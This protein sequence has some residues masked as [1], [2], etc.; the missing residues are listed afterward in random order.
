M[1]E[2]VMVAAVLAGT[3]ILTGGAGWVARIIKGKD[4]N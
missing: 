2:W 3:V 4:R 1:N